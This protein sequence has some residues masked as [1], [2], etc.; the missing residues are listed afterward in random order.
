MLQQF[1]MG[2]QGKNASLVCIWHGMF[3]LGDGLKPMSKNV[4]SVL[5]QINSSLSLLIHH[6]WAVVMMMRQRSGAEITE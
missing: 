6:S 3:D 2:E 5:S 4:F 1:L